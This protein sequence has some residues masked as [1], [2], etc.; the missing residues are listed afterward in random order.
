MS[1]TT[2]TTT[3]TSNKSSNYINMHTTGIG[4]LGRVRE[5]KVRTGKPFLACNIRAMYGEK[6][7]E[8]GIRYTPFDVKAVSTQAQE[9]LLDFM[10][11]ANDK[12]K[13]VTVQFKIGDAE[14]NS[15]QYGPGDKQGQ[16]GVVMKGRLLK[17]QRVW[18]K[19]LTLNGDEQTG[20]VLA[21]EYVEPAREVADEDQARTG[22]NG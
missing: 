17:I 16:A 11:D 6:G 13:R 7:V 12:N 4:Y 8:D 21:Y 1:N 15:F 9:V 2:T 10:A 19:D 3:A 14:I 5:I 20:Q 22:T 18:V